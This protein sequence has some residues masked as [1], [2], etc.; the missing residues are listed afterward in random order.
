MLPSPIPFALSPLF[1][2]PTEFDENM[3]E[4]AAEYQSAADIHSATQIMPP[5]G[6]PS[7]RTFLKTVHCP[8]LY[9]LLLTFIILTATTHMLVLQVQGGSNMTGT[10]LCVNKPHCAAAVRP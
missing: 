9:C 8:T 6:A 5:Y 3:P 1:L 4:V 7:C 10:D 2:T